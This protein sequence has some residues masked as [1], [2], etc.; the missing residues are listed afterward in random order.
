MR[1]RPFIWAAQIL[2]AL[3][4]LQS[5]YSKISGKPIFIELFSAIG[6]EPWGRYMIA[7][8]ELAIAIMLLTPSNATFGAFLAALI[9]VG[10]IFTHVFSIGVEFGGNV[11]LFIMS[12]F[13]SV[14]SSFVVFAKKEEEKDEP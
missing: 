5:F 9:G 3:F 2:T 10:A 11:S 4:L 6:I 13:I 14:L 8:V 12:I 1:K 7:I